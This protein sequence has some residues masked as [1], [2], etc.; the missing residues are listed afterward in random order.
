MCSK[1]TTAQAGTSGHHQKSF[2]KCADHKSQRQLPVIN[3]K[4]SDFSPGQGQLLDNRPARRNLWVW[5]V[6]FQGEIGYSGQISPS[7]CNFRIDYVGE[8]V[9]LGKMVPKCRL[10]WS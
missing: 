4:S 2:L 10:S 7:Q 9:N 8:G 1:D 3:V 5:W 6:G